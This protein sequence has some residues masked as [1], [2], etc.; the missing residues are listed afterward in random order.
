M[1]IRLFR[2]PVEESNRI[3]SGTAVISKAM[4][5]WGNKILRRVNPEVQ[6]VP[7]Q[8]DLIQRSSWRRLQK[9]NILNKS[10]CILPQTR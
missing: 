10:I 4:V 1:G 8:G 3:F 5:A 9:F 7:D 6:S 2:R